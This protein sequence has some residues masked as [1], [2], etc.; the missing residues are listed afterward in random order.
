MLLARIDRY[1]L[2]LILGTFGSIVCILMC[3]MVLEHIPRLLDVTRLSGSRGYIVGQTVLGLLPEYAG[4]GVVVGNYLGIGLAIRK[5]ALRGELPV[6]EA[7]GIGPSRWMRTPIILTIVGAAFV[8]VNQGW[9]MPFGERRLEEIGLRME[10]G[11]FGVNLPSREL[12]DLGDGVT[13]Y[14]DVVADKSGT[15]EGIFLSDGERTYSA[16]SGTFSLTADGAGLVRLANGQVIDNARRG[17]MS[18]TNLT[19]RLP[20]ARK[21]VDRTSSET[22]SLRQA[23]LHSLLVSD[24]LI[25]RSVAYSRI[26]WGLLVPVSGALAF[27][28]ARPP[29]RSSSAIGLLSGLCLLIVFLKSIALLE[30]ANNLNPAIMGFSIGLFWIAAIALLFVW[31]K[32][33]GNGAI[34]MAALSLLSGLPKGSRR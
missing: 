12:V 30:S 27:I 34:D 11:E 24:K 13:L 10:N 32:R 3:L 15:L 18:F 19:F 1:L 7:T 33:A 9:L 26:L 8:L 21:H 16:L 31:H 20:G 5:L 22:R 6:I 23:T 29:M 2:A 14:F 17:V 28:L 4:I 25:S